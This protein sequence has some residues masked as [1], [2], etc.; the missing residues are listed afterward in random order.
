MLESWNDGAT[1]SAIVDFVG[2]VSGDG[3]DFVAFARVAPT[4]FRGHDLRRGL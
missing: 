1:K 3:P 2:R 4:A